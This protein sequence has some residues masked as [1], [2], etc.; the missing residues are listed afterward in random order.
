MLLL[1][2]VTNAL[3]HL[4]DHIG[5]RHGDCSSRTGAS[6]F[7]NGDTKS[8]D[9]GPCSAI[10]CIDI[11]THKTQ[12]GELVQI[13]QEQLTTLVAIQRA[14]IGVLDTEAATPGTCPAPGPVF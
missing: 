13:C 12:L 5:N 7:S 2:L 3:N 1:R 9:S 4:G 10:I 8:H 11:Q 14:G 6:D